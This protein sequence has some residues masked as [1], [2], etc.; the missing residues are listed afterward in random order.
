MKF[1]NIRGLLLLGLLT[2]C[3]GT[4]PDA[5]SQAPASAES[6]LDFCLKFTGYS[7]YSSE[8]ACM[9]AYS[10]GYAHCEAYE[11]GFKGY[12]HD[13]TIMSHDEFGTYTVYASTCCHDYDA[14]GGTA[15][16]D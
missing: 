10:Q 15:P 11:G 3:G 7:E 9:D 12:R 5:P 1:F 16:L 13:C 2:G 8:D 6:A 4:E 14:A